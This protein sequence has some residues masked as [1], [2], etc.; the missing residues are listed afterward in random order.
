MRERDQRNQNKKY[1]GKLRKFHG[2]N[3]PDQDDGDS[4]YTQEAEWDEL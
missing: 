2:L 4:K 1:Q 3:P